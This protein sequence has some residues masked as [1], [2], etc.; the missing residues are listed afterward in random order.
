MQSNVMAELFSTKTASI[1]TDL[2]VTAHMHIQSVWTTE[3][4]A[5]FRAFKWSDI[6][7][8]PHVIPQLIFRLEP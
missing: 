1:R 8:V 6:V 2:G 3:F 5:T 4:F 7:V